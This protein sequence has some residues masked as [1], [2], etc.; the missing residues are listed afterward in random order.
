MTEES[1]DNTLPLIVSIQICC[2]IAQQR[3]KRKR[4]TEYAILGVIGNV[5]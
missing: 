2:L 3:K 4:K 1:S 5:R